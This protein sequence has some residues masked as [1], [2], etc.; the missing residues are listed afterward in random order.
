MKLSEFQT[1]DWKIYETLEECIVRLHS[2][3]PKSYERSVQ[4]STNIGRRIHSKCHREAEGG[5][6]EDKSS[7]EKEPHVIIVRSD[8]L[9]QTVTYL[10]N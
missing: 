4:K 8:A 9:I 1:D 2:R 3:A 10:S 6:R 5:E 7:W